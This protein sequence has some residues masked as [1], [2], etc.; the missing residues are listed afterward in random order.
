[1]FDEIDDLRVNLREAADGFR[2]SLD[3]DELVRAGRRRQRRNRIAGG[4]AGAAALAVVVGFGIPAVLNTAPGIPAAPASSPSPPTPPA[5]A[6]E[7]SS[8]AVDMSDWQTFASPEYP[9]TFQY[10]PDWTVDDDLYGD[11]SDLGKIDGCDSVNCVLFVNPPDAASAAPLELIRNGFAPDDASGGDLGSVEEIVTI[12]DLLVWGSESARTVTQAVILSRSNGSDEPVDYMLGATAPKTTN[13][14]AVGDSNPRADRPESHFSFATNVGN[15]GGAYDDDGRAQ[16]L[17][18]LGSTRPNP[19]F[20]P[21]QP[22][23]D[24]V[25]NEVMAVY[26]GM[27]APDLTL[28][29][30]SWKLLEVEKANLSV[31]VP[32]KWKV[33]DDGEGVIWIEAP[34]GYIV[35]LLT[36]GMLEACSAGQ[37]PGSKSLATVD[38][39]EAGAPGFTGTPEIRWVNGGQ[40]PVWV[41]LALDRVEN[42]CF[43]RYLDFG[44]KPV[45]LGSADNSANPTAKEL[46]QA[47]AILASA[48]RLS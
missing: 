13:L 21:T 18:I 19:D 3:A 7:P 29:S 23:R 30:A 35:D 40:Y 27:A 45:Y 6:D 2:P 11:G 25:G 42:A 1:M 8:F 9:V 31:R 12:P 15:V 33:T 44:G 47:I 41:G 20:D 22:V 10:P 4:L 28:S 36:N 16:V 5:P 37:L 14:L 32:P 48:K 24:E 39:L 38:G 34:S 46:D 26:D 43:E 17:T